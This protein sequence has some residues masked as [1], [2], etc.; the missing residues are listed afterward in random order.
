METREYIISAFTENRAGVLNRITALFLRRKINIESLKVSE[1][2]IKGIS[3]FTIVAHTTD[4]IVEKLVKQME[5]IVDVIKAEY[6]TPE[7]LIVHQIALYKTGKDALEGDNVELIT[8]RHNAR[9]V[10]V[11]DNYAVFE[12]T[13]Y[14]NEID[15]LRDELKNRNLL[16]QF[17]SSGAVVLHHESLEERLKGVF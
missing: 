6:Y 15:A 12:K 1:T 5:R 14:K 9:L 10:E 7:S 11:S 17:T 16:L 3:A 8:R 2:P 4:Q 13:G